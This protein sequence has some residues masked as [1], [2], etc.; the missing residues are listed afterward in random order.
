[1]AQ[2]NILILNENPQEIDLLTQLCR[3]IGS[4]YHSSDLEKTIALLRSIDFNVL[5]V[6]SSLASY[7]SLKGLF[8]KTTSIIIN[9]KDEKE[10][11]EIKSEWPS[12]FSVEYHITPYK[13][14]V[15]A[16]FLR[17]LNTAA[18]YSLLRINVEN[19]TSSIERNEAKLKEAYFEIKEINN[20]IG[21]NLI[22]ETKKHIA[23]GA[24]YILL[25]REKQKTED[26]LKK[27]YKANDVISLLD[28]V[29]DIKEIIKAEGITIY[30]MEEHKTLGKYL[31]PLV[32]DD[33]FLSHSD[34]S[35]YIA[36]IDSQDFAASVARSGQEINISDLTFE[37][38]MS[39]RYT[40]QLKSPLK[41]IL[42][43]PIKHEQD[44]TGVLEVYN[45]VSTGNF[46][47]RGF[48]REDQK[49]LR[50]LSE[51]I[52]IAI[53]KLNLIQYDALT[54][55]LRPDP[56][57]NKAILKLK[58][59]DKRREEEGSYALVMGD[60]DW[61]K[62]YNDR[63]GH[64]AGN[65]CLRELAKVMKSSIREEDLLC[66]YGGEEFLFFLTGLTDPEEAYNLTERIRKNIEDY[67]FE[68]QDYQPQKNL[69]MSFGISHF[70]RERIDS[71]KEIT[72]S[73]L[74]KIAN[75]ADLAMVEA[76][77]M[78][79]TLRPYEKGAEYFSKNRIC[80]YTRGLTDKSKKV[81]AIPFYREPFFKEK[82]EFERFHTSVLL[83][84]K[85]E[86]GPRITNTINL[87][88][89]GARIPSETEIPPSETL[90]LILILGSTTAHI[91]G[92]VV[93]SQKVGR[94]HPHYYSGLKF[95]DLPLEERNILESYLTSL[96]KEE[97]TSPP[98]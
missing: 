45:K 17:T 49:I 43:V 77:K 82:R 7:S 71:F 98:Q 57:F 65:R 85:R 61:F 52:S 27:L 93:Y 55:L 84:N 97:K 35:K 16:S 10:L 37:K 69:T 94:D 34:F 56:F 79:S 96:S 3:H 1:M 62:N 74:I 75:E 19:M 88:L 54:G 33:I 5:V 83:I 13:E 42:C 6:D 22:N 72:K 92:N 31:K 29:Y 58:S 87:S 41:S 15:K 47:N 90:D 89:V 91:K 20:L 32:W 59:H 81:G 2:G 30:I 66:R 44:V 70:T 80:T 14:H 24:K 8:K 73:E 68:Y 86:K 26:L 76:K 21:N 4:V 11:Q 64:E 78:P 51:H 39:K 38:R 46:S 53:T 63:N 36:L 28:I 12:N 67:H 25:Q 23:I 48:S 50:R 95:K 18:E 9:G 40:E 60:V